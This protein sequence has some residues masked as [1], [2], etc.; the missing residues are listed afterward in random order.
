MAGS[1]RPRTNKGSGASAFQYLRALDVDYVKID[2]SYIRDVT[3]NRDARSFVRSMS[4]LCH[5][6]GM[7]TIAEMVDEP[8]SLLASN[9]GAGFCFTKILMDTFEFS[10][11]LERSA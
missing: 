8:F 1:V 3:S 7:Q 5:E 4:N 6:L 10:E 2:G 9:F 11:R